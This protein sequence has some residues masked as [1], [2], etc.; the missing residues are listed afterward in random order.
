MKMVN[1]MSKLVQE[2][3]EAAGKASSY[4]MLRTYSR[5]LVA[6]G[7]LVLCLAGVEW[8]R[9]IVLVLRGRMWIVTVTTALTTTGVGL[10]ICAGSE[11]LEVVR[12]VAM[13]L[14]RIADSISRKGG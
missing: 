3:D 8:V 13:D 5:A 1:D 14:R 12:H 6:L 11:L 9:S 10:G 7:L 2:R 4:P